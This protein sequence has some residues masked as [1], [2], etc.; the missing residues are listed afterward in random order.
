ML[1][2]AS[3]EVGRGQGE[4]FDLLSAIFPVAKRHLAVLKSLQ[5]RVAQ[6]D[7]KDIS[8][9]IF[10]D[11]FSAPGRLGMNDPFLGAP[12]GR[13]ARQQAPGFERIAHFGP[14]DDGESVDWHQEFW[15]FGFQP[16]LAVGRQSTG[17]DQ[18]VRVWVIRQGAS[19]GVED[20]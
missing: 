8:S 10:Q 15:V 16:A 7:A 17:A 18:K 20:A 13:H 5:A 1:K 12:E 14:E 9:Q 6:R 19:P 2:K 4:A 3:Q 11:F